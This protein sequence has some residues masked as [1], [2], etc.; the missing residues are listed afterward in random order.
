MH[1]MGEIVIALD[2]VSQGIYTSKISATTTKSN[3][4]YTKKYCKIIC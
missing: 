4:F 3:D 1:I 2:K